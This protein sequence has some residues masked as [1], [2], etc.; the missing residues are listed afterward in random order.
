[1]KKF[2]Y[3]ILIALILGSISADSI[4]DEWANAKG[5]LAKVK[6]F[7]QKYGIYDD[8]VNY[9]NNGA[10]SAAQVLCVKVIGKDRLCKEIIT[11]LW[12]FLQKYYQK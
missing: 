2:L 3:L 4:E 9:L 10:R 11:I 6:K 5:T 12:D 1:M 8:L 7:L